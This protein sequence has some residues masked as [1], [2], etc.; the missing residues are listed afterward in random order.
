MSHWTENESDGTLIGAALAGDRTAMAA[1]VRRYQRP[2]LRVAQSNLQHREWAEDVVQET[3]LCVFK[4]LHTY[5]SRFAFRTWLWTILL[6]QCRRHQNKR[7]RTPH[8][9]AWSDGQHTS[10]GPAFPV[11][12]DT[13]SCPSATLLAKERRTRLREVLER[14]PSVQADALRLRFFGGL[15]YQEIADTMQCSLSSAKSR[16]RLGLVRLS[17]LSEL[18]FLAV[19]EPARATPAEGGENE[20]Q[21]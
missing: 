4:S 21:S 14:L 17:Q 5:D 2:L 3:F 16:V 20:C 18:H 10:D 1:L 6:N 8:V 19:E 7:A 12:E 11:L 15:K 13:A 9:S